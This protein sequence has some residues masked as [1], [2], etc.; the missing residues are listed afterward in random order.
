MEN[1]SL[2]FSVTLAEKSSPS[3][4]H[5]LEHCKGKHTFAVEAE[6]CIAVAEE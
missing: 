5:G 6:K 1:F 3:Q 4:R 2:L